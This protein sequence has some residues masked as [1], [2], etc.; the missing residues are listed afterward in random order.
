MSKNFEKNCYMF[1]QNE[2]ETNSFLF[3]EGENEIPKN[4]Q[5]QGKN[6]LK[7]SPPRPP[8]AFI[9]YRK[10]I[11][12]MLKKEPD[13]EFHN[14]HTSKISKIAGERWHSESEEIKLKFERLANAAKL[15]NRNKKQSKLTDELVAN[16]KYQT[17]LP[18]PDLNNTVNNKQSKLTDKNI[19]NILWEN[20]AVSPFPQPDLISQLPMPDLSKTLSPLPTQPNLNTINIFNDQLLFEVPIILTDIYSYDAFRI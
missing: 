18:Q 4:Q 7:R 12:S 9:L 16:P 2:L 17:Q 10:H 13:F 19:T 20:K 14:F 15:L 3:S 5:S 11:C 6:R 1:I 8:N